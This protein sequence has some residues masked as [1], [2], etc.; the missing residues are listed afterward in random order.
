MCFCIALTCPPPTPLA[1]ASANMRKHKRKGLS[2]RRLVV[3]CWLA[4]SLACSPLRCL[5]SVGGLGGAALE[6]DELLALVS[7][8]VQPRELL[9]ALS[10]ELVDHFALLHRQTDVVEAVDEAMLLEGFDLEGDGSTVRSRDFLRGKVNFD[11]LFSLCVLHQLA[12]VSLRQSN[13]EH[14]VLEAI[15]EEDVGEA[16]GDQAPDAHVVDGPGGVLT[17]GSTAEVV[18]TDQDLGLSEGLPV[19][20]KLRLLGAIRLV[21]DLEEGPLTEAGSL[22]G[23]QELLG[24]DH[25]GVH[26]LHVQRSSDTLQGGELGHAGRHR[27]T[28]C[29]ARCCSCRRRLEGEGR[30]SRDGLGANELLP[31]RRRLALGLV[32]LT[33]HLANVCE[34]TSDG[35]CSSHGR[36]HQ[37]SSALGS[38]SALEISV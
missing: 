19:E 30:G 37:V 28:S 23:L 22:D 27:A 33:N 3:A 25:V 14:A 34:S 1:I 6:S 8:A 15:A 18:A 12:D 4:R 5:G 21:P 31:G 24:D 38:L 2:T 26:I 35:S 9:G 32:L 7:V 36:A 16:G 20:N 13:G 29:S 10:L 11:L 17:R